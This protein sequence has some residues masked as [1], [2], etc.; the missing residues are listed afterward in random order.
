[1]IDFVR[2]GLRTGRL[3]GNERTVV[4][5]HAVCSA[6]IFFSRGGLEIL[7]RQLHLIQQPRLALR[8]LSIQMPLQFLSQASGAAI[9]GALA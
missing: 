1:M 2:K 6:A 8:A 4:V 3:R 9:S 7:Y 5:F